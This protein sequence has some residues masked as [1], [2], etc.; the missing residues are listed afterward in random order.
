MEAVYSA[1]PLILK[2]RSGGGGGR[3]RSESFVQLNTDVTF[4]SERK[5]LT[6]AKNGSDARCRHSG[7]FFQLYT[8]VNS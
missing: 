5:V 7:T 1:V 4:E 8:R 6:Y 3:G 2:L